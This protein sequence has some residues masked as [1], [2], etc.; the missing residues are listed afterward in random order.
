MS[1]FPTYEISYTIELFTAFLKKKNVKSS[2][3]VGAFK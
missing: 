1:F 2:A 3:D